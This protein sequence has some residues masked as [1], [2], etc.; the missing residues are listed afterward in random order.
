[1]P[2]LWADTKCGASGVHVMDTKKKTKETPRK[3]KPLRSSW[4][5]SASE[6]FQP[7]EFPMKTVRALGEPGHVRELPSSAGQLNVQ[8]SKKREGLTASSLFVL[9]F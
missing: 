3:V 2:S 4:I 8:K 9:K 1:M 5:V 7:L 6:F